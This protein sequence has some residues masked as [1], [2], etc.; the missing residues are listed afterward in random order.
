MMDIWNSRL[1]LAAI[2]LTIFLVGCKGYTEANNVKHFKIEMCDFLAADHKDNMYIPIAILGSGPAGASAGIYG[3][4]SMVK[5][6]VFQG[7]KPGGLLT[8][9]SEVENWPGIIKK[10]GLEIMDSLREQA[11]HFGAIFLDDLVTSLDVSSWPFK[12]QTESGKTY[13]AFA[14]V[15]ATGASPVKLL[16]PGEQ[17]YFGKGVGT[18]A[19]CDAA[20]Y[21]GKEVVVVGG[22]DSAAEEAMQ[23]ASYA[24][25]V[26]IFVRKE[27]M[28]AAES[29]QSLLKGYSNISIM[30]NIE[31]KQVNGDG[32]K[33]TSL[34]ILD[35]KTG[36]T[37]DFKV[38]G[39]FLAIGH[40][41]NTTLFKNIVP[42]DE[43][44]Y[45]L[46]Q[47]RT[48]QTYIQ[49]V[50]AGGD[51]HDHRYRQAVTASGFGSAAGIDAVNFL[52][53]IGFNAQVQS[54]LIDHI[55]EGIK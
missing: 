52:K 30:Y 54:A 24:S 28:R 27:R 14:L 51:C 49:G 46:L 6:V 8:E 35:N 22:G 40:D 50:F 38:D 5:T 53:E 15:I 32:N 11:E 23:L 17:E 25:K 45:I 36:Q 10:R 47:D 31:V 39:M 42:M 48:Q 2:S 43:K 16:I 41:P 21:K 55:F 29:M 20:F 19:L 1:K 12:L 9:T 3:A 18:C 4:R 13:Y 26:T 37:S 34:T 44:G 33:V 7:S